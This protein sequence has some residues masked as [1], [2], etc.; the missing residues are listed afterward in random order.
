MGIAEKLSELNDKIS[1]KA[2]ACG[3]EPKEIKLIAVSKT[4]PVSMIEEAIACSIRDFGENRPQELAEKY[5]QIPNVNWHLIG[6]L[7]RNKVRHIIDKTELIHSVDSYALAEEIE[8]RASMVSKVQ[9]ILIQVNIS[10]EEGKSG[11]GPEDAVE[12][13][14][15]ISQLPH[16]SIQ[17]LMTISVAGLD[18]DG[19]YEIFSRLRQ[20]AETIKELNIDGVEMKELSMGMTHD[21]EAAIAAG[22]TL[23]RV[24]SG[25]FGSRNYVD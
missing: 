8:K 5:Q 12:L 13:C 1:Q 21:Y 11:V 4:K 24:G 20:L 2:I 7:Q 22:A 18:Y 17:G 14:K 3:R 15:K 6:Q 25:I 16:I 23:L 19:N 10:G 9:K